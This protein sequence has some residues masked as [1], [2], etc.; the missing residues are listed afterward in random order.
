M[1]S[2]VCCL[3]RSVPGPKFSELI[4]A[5]T[6][7]H[8]SVM[9]AA[10]VNI[11]KTEHMET[12]QGPRDNAAKLS[13]PKVATSRTMAGTVKITRATKARNP[14][15]IVAE[16]FRKIACRTFHVFAISARSSL[17]THSQLNS[18]IITTKPRQ[19]YRTQYV[20]HSKTPLNKAIATTWTTW[21]M[22]TPFV[23]IGSWMMSLRQLRKTVAIHAPRMR[24]LSL[25][26]H[27]SHISRKPFM[28]E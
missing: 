1:Y 22:P 21:T 27:S 14:N 2:I 4:S 6:R 18:S 28:S 26:A 19:R 3:E 20:I 16:A 25:R 9:S 13:M 12:M 10:I 17:L 8:L 24:A 15:S 5:G 23:C 7:L 11:H